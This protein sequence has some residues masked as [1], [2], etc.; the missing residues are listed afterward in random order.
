VCIVGKISI[1]TL[2]RGPARANQTSAYTEGQ[3]QTQ[4]AGYLERAGSGLHDGIC[5]CWNRSSKPR[6]DHCHAPGSIQSSSGLFIAGTVESSNR[7]GR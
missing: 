6:L 5:W 7:S 3:R 4:T 1:I 2:R